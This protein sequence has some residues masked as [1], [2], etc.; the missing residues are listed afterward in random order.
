[1][2][3]ERTNAAPFKFHNGWLV[4]M[5]NA[6]DRR[7]TWPERALLREP[8]GST[9]RAAAAGQQLVA[10]GWPALAGVEDQEET[11]V[12]C[13]HA[14]ATISRETVKALAAESEGTRITERSATGSD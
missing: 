10:S 14:M 7:P 9:P 5:D 13:A 1:M 11:T 6:C 8:N 3:N 4:V 12:V 2:H